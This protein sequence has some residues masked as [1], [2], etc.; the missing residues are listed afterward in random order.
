MKRSIGFAVALMI[1]LGV[2]LAH[3]N[4][5]GSGK[6]GHDL[7]KLQQ[8][9]WFC[10]IPGGFIEVHCASPGAFTSSAS[11][12]LLVFDTTEFD[13]TNAPLLGAELV[14][15]GDL[16]AGQPCAPNNGPW[17]PLDVDGDGTPDLFA[18]HFYP[19]HH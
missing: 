9:G 10:F 3:A 18:C 7:V 17:T 15:R 11:V 5:N 19:I 14:L 16:Y 12:P 6:G 8:A 1:T 13:D 2:S 4:N